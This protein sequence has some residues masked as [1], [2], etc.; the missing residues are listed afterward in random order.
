M[1]IDESKAIVRRY[2][3]EALNRADLTTFDELLSTDCLINGVRPGLDAIRQSWISLRRAFPD[4]RVSVEEMVAE[5]DRVASRLTL[6]GTHKGDLPGL[7]ATEK[8]AV[9]TAIRI[10]RTAGGK[11]VEIWEQVDRL[12][13]RQQLS[14]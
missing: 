2:F 5:G 7:A 9:W 11:I 3:D 14:P 12:G 10:D 4:L 6:Q 8:R 1:G 13:L